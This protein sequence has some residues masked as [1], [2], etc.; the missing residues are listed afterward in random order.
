MKKEQGAN[1]TEVTLFRKFQ[2]KENLPREVISKKREPALSAFD[3]LFRME[4]ADLVICLHPLGQNTAKAMRDKMKESELFMFML[5]E[6]GRRRPDVAEI[7]SSIFQM[8]IARLSEYFELQI[9]NGKMPDINPLWAT[10]VFYQLFR[11]HIFI[12]R[13]T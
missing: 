5:I 9:K 8:N 12:K 1:V 13:S 4:D 7:F 2:S 11:P 6:E 3:S 10:L